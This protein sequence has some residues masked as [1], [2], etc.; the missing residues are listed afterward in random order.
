MTEK[1]KATH[2]DRKAIL[3]VRQSS[4]QQVVHHLEGQRLQYAM[5]ERVTALGWHTVDVIDEDL[6]KSA[7]GRVERSG[8]QRMVAE[9]S[10]AQVGVVAAWE[11]SRFSR[12]SREW[13]H[14]I[15]V[16]RIV[17]TLLADEETIYDARQSND[18]LLLGLKGSL[19]EYELDLFRQRSQKA[20]QQKASRAAL[21]MNAP[22]GY[23]NAGE[24]R[25]EKDPDRRV[26]QAIDT[27]FTKFLELG[28]ARQVL[29][30]FLDRGL[31]MPSVRWE[32][33]SWKTHWRTPTYHGIL[34][35]LKHPIY[36]GA[37]AWGMTRSET[38]LDKGKPRR[39]SQVKRRDEWLVL[40]RDHHEGYVDACHLCY[41]ARRMLRREQKLDSLK[42]VFLYSGRGKKSKK[43]K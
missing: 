7:G 32:D 39:V 27:I 23:V 26:Q 8:F 38:V 6:G 43:K 30:W 11:L 10:L 1:V 42:P 12:N 18:R 41:N 21:G 34:R 17:D 5:R 28:T 25:Q 24:G 33:G 14:L 22:V 35:V 36:A 31:E 13:Q 2:L 15:E 9:V 19:N 40:Q 4:A 20:R 29:M 3:Y 37:Y 16:C